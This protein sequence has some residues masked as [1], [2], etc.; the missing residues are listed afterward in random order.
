MALTEKSLCGFVFSDLFLQNMLKLFIL[1]FSDTPKLHK[2]TGFHTQN[3]FSIQKSLKF[4]ELFYFFS[5]CFL[6]KH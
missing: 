4:G 5:L 6:P 3:M 2:F 1:D